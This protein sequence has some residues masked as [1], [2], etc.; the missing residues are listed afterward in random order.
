MN[1]DLNRLKT[2]YAVYRRKSVSA[3]A[4]ELY[5]TQSAASQSLSRLEKELH[6]P[7]FLRAGRKLL[8]TPAA[9]SLY[10]LVHP[11][12]LSLEHGLAGLEKRAAA[13]SGVLRIGAPVEFGS[14]HLVRLCA[15]FRRKYPE[16]SFALS[17][18]QTAELLSALSAGKL[19]FAFADIFKSGRGY[20]REFSIFT[21]KLVAQEELALACSAAYAK[22]CLRGKAGP[23]ELL[24]L[25][26]IDYNPHAPALNGWFEHHYGMPHPRPQLAL[27][28][29]SVQALISAIESGMGLGVVP[30]HLIAPGIA[31]GRLVE[32]R[33]RGAPL[34]NSISLLRLKDGAPGAAEKAF[35]SQFGHAPLK[36][37]G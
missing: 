18:G 37:A 11:F 22:A 14:R 35:L 34:L 10:E 5:V 4:V 25:S 27:S 20:S 31:S 13:P 24:G 8:P 26:F 33:G 12:F 30:R 23:R 17:F 28:V 32:V 15:D 36:L 7:L 9:D 21:I 3:A 1:A 16:V 19:D 2:F 29:E 6:T